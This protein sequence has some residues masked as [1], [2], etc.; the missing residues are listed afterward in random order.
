MRP[1]RNLVAGAVA[2]ILLLI[3][4]VWQD[5]IVHFFEN[6]RV[7][8]AGS[9]D[10]SFN[11]GSFESLKIENAALRT[12]CAAASSSPRAPWFST[13]SADRARYNLREVQIYSR[14]PF[15]N[16]A[17]VSINA[18]SE[19]GI[20]AG[21]PVLAAPGV[22]FGK[23]KTVER[24]RSEV[25]TIFDPSWRSTVLV[26]DA[27]TKAVFVGAS[28][29][30]LDLIPKNASTTAG[31]VILNADPDFPLNLL[32]G[33]VAS[34][35]EGANALWLQAKVD[36]SFRFDALRRVFVVLNYP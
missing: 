19:D 24:T 18:G 3:I 11:Y 33:N 1:F 16:E 8:F 20:R 30:Y 34:L 4:L 15:N 32:I 27:R 36:P 6:V 28:F 2:L 26:G 14:Y 21:M 13:S 29:P 23:V 17:S 7:F 35:Q 12:Q 31:D 25:E 22:L 10:P 9:A 5:P